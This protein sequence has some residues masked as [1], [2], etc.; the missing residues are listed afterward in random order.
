MKAFKCPRCNYHEPIESEAVDWA[1]VDEWPDMMSVN[2]MR[3][4]NLI[5]EA[6]CKLKQSM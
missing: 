1:F 5:K 3:G 6:L 2:E 4:L